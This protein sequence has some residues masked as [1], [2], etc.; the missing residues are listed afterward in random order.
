MGNL[1]LIGL[2]A[3]FIPILGC[4]RSNPAGSPPQNDSTHTAIIMVDDL[5]TAGI[6]AD[7]ARITIASMTADI[8]TLVTQYG[9]GCA[10]HE[11]KL[12]G[13]IRFLTSSPLQ[14]DVVLSHNANGDAC[15]AL[16]TD[17]LRFSLAH[18]REMFQ[19]SY[20]TRGTL[21]LRVHEPG[22]PEPLSPLIRY[23]F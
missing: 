9:G 17:T 15:K 1:F 5:S 11:F 10:S 12:F 6:A 13:S 19:S 23:D 4:S 20:S 16:I 14:A 3:V 22:A 8:L 21:L 2:S 18:L 7:N